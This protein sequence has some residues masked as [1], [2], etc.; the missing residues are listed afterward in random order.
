MRTDKTPSPVLSSL[1]AQSEGLRTVRIT[2]CVP[3]T[4]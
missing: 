3:R 1:R 4:A 2:V